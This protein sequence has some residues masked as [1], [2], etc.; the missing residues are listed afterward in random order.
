MGVRAAL[1]GCAGARLL[2]LIQ[3]CAQAPASEPPG[4]LSPIRKLGFGGSGL[5]TSSGPCPGPVSP[6]SP[7][8]LC[9]WVDSGSPSPL[10]AGLPGPLR[11]LL[12]FVSPRW[13]VRA[14]H[15]VPLQ[16]REKV[17]HSGRICKYCD[18][19]FLLCL[20]FRRGWVKSRVSC[21]CLGGMGEGVILSFL[22]IRK[23][24]SQAGDPPS[25]LKLETSNTPSIYVSRCPDSPIGPA[26]RCR[27]AH[28]A[29]RVSCLLFF[30]L[31]RHS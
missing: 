22:W 9:G 19:I 6:G 15:L 8:W 13:G 24:R 27:L 23:S 31:Q 20:F 4:P 5:V 18:S 29:G 3:P 10:G 11:G 12:P 17:A 7:Q 2:L 21:L 28:L 1:P 16:S 25:W 14:E 26:S 30:F